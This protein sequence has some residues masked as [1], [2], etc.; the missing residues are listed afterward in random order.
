[1]RRLLL[2]LLMMLTPAPLLGQSNL[3]GDWQATVH[4]FG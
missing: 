3:S 4:F 2:A 1:M